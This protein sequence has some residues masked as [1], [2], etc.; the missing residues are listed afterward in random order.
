MKRILPDA[1]AKTHVITA[2]FEYEDGS[3]E[4]YTATELIG[5]PVVQQSRLE[6]GELV[7]MPHA[8]VGEYASVSVEF[9]NTG[10]TPL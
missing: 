1:A 8:S 10:K 9:Y 3:G 7:Y 5:I 2:N 4:A 6:V